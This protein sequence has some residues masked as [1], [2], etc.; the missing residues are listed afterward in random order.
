[1]VNEMSSSVYTEI[2]YSFQITPKKGKREKESYSKKNIFFS[3][4]PL[5]AGIFF[6]SVLIQPWYSTFVFSLLF[7]YRLFPVLQISSSLIDF[8]PF[9]FS[10]SDLITI[11]AQ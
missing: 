7:L 2:I 10:V 4:S 3:A 6:D 5:S 8:F 1:M 11:S 9:F